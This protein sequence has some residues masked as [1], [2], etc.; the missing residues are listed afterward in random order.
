MPIK[1]NSLHPEYLYHI[2][3]ADIT[4]SELIWRPRSNGSNRCESEPQTPRI[5]FSTSVTGCFLALGNCLSPNKDIQILRTYRRVHY[6]KPTTEQVLDVNLTNE[7]WRLSP[8][9]LTKIGALKTTD[10]KD[11]EF[12]NYL[13]FNPGR[14]DS[15][16][17]QATVRVNLNS[18]ME[19]F[20]YAF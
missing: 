17:H 1:H 16:L 2:T 9:K 7:A 12:F 3:Q 8:T 6:Y 11:S 14:F 13:D 4:D 19:R 10:F 20:Q 18:F 5:C 15:V